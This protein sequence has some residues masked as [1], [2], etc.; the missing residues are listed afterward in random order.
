MCY[1]FSFSFCLFF[2]LIKQLS[3]CSTLRLFVTSSEDY[4][5]KI[6]NCDNQLVREMSFDESLCGVCF[7]NSRGDIL[8]GFQSQ[9]S[10][11]TILNYLPLSYLEIVSKM[12]FDN[13]PFEDHVQFDDLLKFWYDPARVPRMSLEA[14]KRRPL[15]PQEVKRPKKKRKVGEPAGRMKVMRSSLEDKALHTTDDLYVSCAALQ[16]MGMIMFNLSQESR[17]SFSFL[18]LFQKLFP[19]LFSVMQ[20]KF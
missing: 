19:V 15:E 4:S 16:E 18:T 12:H 3:C 7:A 5:V 10:L 1:E 14:S 6:W 20:G 11:V 9:I 17:S 8:V 2:L 13:D